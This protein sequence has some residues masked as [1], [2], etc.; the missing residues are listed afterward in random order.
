MTRA[1]GGIIRSQ[2]QRHRGHVAR[3]HRPSRHCAASISASPSGVYQGR[4]PLDIAQIDVIGQ[5]R[6]D[7][8]AVRED[9]ERNFALEVVPMRIRATAD[10]GA[11]PQAGQHRRLGPSKARLRSKLDD[12]ALTF[13]FTFG[14]PASLRVRRIYS[15]KR[16]IN[17]SFRGATAVMLGLV[18]TAVLPPWLFNSITLATIFISVRS[19]A[20]AVPLGCCL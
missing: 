2:K 11:A 18:P 20:F 16:T 4:T 12:A 7:Q 17:R 19:V 3:L 5:S 8:S 10:I 14:S 9:K 15:Y 6:A 13:P 1:H